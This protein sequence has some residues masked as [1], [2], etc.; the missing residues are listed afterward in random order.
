M[1][2]APIVTSNRNL[3]PAISG[4][5]ATKLAIFGST[6]LNC[7]RSPI[8]LVAMM[9][10]LSLPISST[11]FAKDWPQIN[12][13]NRDGT[14]PGEK[15]LENWPSGGLKKIWAHPVGQG[16]SG[17]VVS[18]DTVI[19]FHRP[20]TQY[21]VEALNAKTG[22]LI[23][24]QELPSEYRGG[25]PDGDTGP[26]AVPLV[27]DGLVYLFGTGG[28][29]FCLDLVDGKKVWEKNV[30]QIYQGPTGYFGSGSSPV[31]IDGKLMVNVGG[32]QGTQTA[33]VAFDPKTGD[34][35]WKSFDDR[36]SYSSP[37]EMIVGGKTVAVFITRLNLIGLDPANGE[38]LFQTQ[39]GARGPTVNGAMPVKI[40]EYL[41]INSAYG[42]G[43][44]WINLVG[45]QP[46]IEWENDRTFSSQYS[47][48]VAAN[49]VLFGTAGR[50]DMGNGSFRCIDPNNGKVLWSE[51]GFAVGHTLFIDG[52]LLVL[53]CKGGFHVLNPNP[54][55][56]DRIFQTSLF[57][58]KSRAMPAVA[59]GLL[60]ARSNAR[61]GKAELICVEIGPSH[62]KL[63]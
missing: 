41:F 60:Y 13:P 58:S 55:K 1:S 23:W 19:V 25:G 36:A 2:V 61:Q 53:D 42:V 52:K 29:L 24:K 16:Y 63:P 37:I 27:H 49:G 8:L 18:G 51:D 57:N 21:L 56:F 48:P 3:R 17:P 5:A 14:A 31:V 9:L 10:V 45:G 35:L 28:N 20:G 43:A 46:G 39:F 12:G 34:E 38:V 33:V 47:T 54:K 7:W 62:P 4:F 15:L 40:G 22:S 6:K 50:E 11:V 26:K 44:K 30:L 32:K 59:N